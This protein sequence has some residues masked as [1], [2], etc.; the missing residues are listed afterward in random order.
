MTRWLARHVEST[1][2]AERTRLRALLPLDRTWP[3]R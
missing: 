2:S 3:R 1:L